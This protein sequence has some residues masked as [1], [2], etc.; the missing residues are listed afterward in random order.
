MVYIFFKSMKL[1]RKIWFLYH[2]RRN[3]IIIQLNSDDETIKKNIVAAI[4]KLTNRKF[5]TS[6][7]CVKLQN[8]IFWMAS[9]FI[10]Q[11]RRHS[12][13]PLIAR[14]TEYIK[15]LFVI[16]LQSFPIKSACL[17]LRQKNHFKMHIYDRH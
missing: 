14:V 15:I 11:Y 9:N 4:I 8:I 3:F 13:L 17:L 6:K 1:M 7:F 5:L 2:N 10:F 16:F 12:N